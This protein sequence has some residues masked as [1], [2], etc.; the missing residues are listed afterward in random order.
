VS[1]SAPRLSTAQ[2]AGRLGVKRS[3]LYAY[4]ARGLLASTP[5]EL[6]GSSFDPLEVESL[7]AGR[8]RGAGTGSG[9]MP[10]RPLMVLDWGLTLLTEDGLYFR[11]VPAADLADRCDFEHAVTFFWTGAPGSGPPRSEGERIPGPQTA[12]DPRLEGMSR[13]ADR[14]TMLTLLAASRDAHRADLTPEAV[15][16]A[17]RRLLALFPEALPRRGPAR[18]AEDSFAGGLW[19]RIA[20]DAPG[21]GDVALLD[22]ALVLCIDHDLAASTMAARIAASARADLYACVTAALAAL[23]GDAHGSATVAAWNLLTETMR[24]GRPEAALSRQVAAGH[25]IPGFGH[26]VY[27]GEDPRAAALLRRMRA[28]PR[29]AAVTHAADRVA[30]V[31]RA[32][33][34]RE[35][36]L[37]LALAAVV[38][39]AGG[40]PEAAQAVFAIGRTVGWTAHVLD[41]YEQPALRLRPQSRYVGP[42]AEPLTTAGRPGRRRR[43][44]DR[45]ADRPPPARRPR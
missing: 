43:S 23:S 40:P 36:N 18:G 2:A 27:R 19:A 31:V 33:L 15:F 25:G 10:G 38:V 28:L 35:P 24:T 5:S 26:P 3:T 1:D 32:R 8:R 44:E 9:A 12:A 45:E 16:R 20:G 29:Y 34:G 4:V 21:P 22:A 17:A 39:G 30:G 6:G 42:A 37:D 14:L 41:E 11:G 13:V 7:A